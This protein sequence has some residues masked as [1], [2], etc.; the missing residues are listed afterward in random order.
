MGFQNGGADGNGLFSIL[1]RIV[2]ALLHVDPVR[3]CLCDIGFARYLPGVLVG[4]G[5]LRIVPGVLN[6][7]RFDIFAALG[8][9]I[10]SHIRQHFT[11]NVRCA[12]RDHQGTCV[13]RNVG[14]PGDDGKSGIL[15]LFQCGIKAGCVNGGKTD[16]IG[17]A[18]NRIVDDLNLIGYGRVRAALIVDG[19]APLFGIFLRA[20]VC[21]FKEC[22]AG[23]LRDKDN[24]LS[25]HVAAGRL[26]SCGRCRR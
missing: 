4:H 22:V 19:E 7:I 6:L 14:V 2:I 10:R 8:Q 11:E 23:N 12:L 5:R 13:R 9:S 1:I 16:G 20:L 24:R 3:I 25:L 18:G 26:G 21:G 17:A 15:G